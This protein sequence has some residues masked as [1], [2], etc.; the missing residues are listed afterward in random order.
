MNNS[1][2]IDHY[3]ELINNVSDQTQ[4]ELISKNKQF[5]KLIINPSLKIQKFAIEQGIPLKEISNPS[6]E[7]IQIAIKNSSRYG[8]DYNYVAKNVTLQFCVAINEY[9][10]IGY[11]AEN[12]VLDN[13]VIDWA[14]EEL[15][16][17]MP[18][19]D[20]LRV[21]RKIQL[22][23]KQRIRLIELSN[24][25]IFGKYDMV[26]NFKE[27]TKIEID[28]LI[29][30]DWKNSVYIIKN[31]IQKQNDIDYTINQLQQNS[32]FLNECKDNDKNS[33]DSFINMFLSL[34]DNDL[35]SDFLYQMTYIVKSPSLNRKIRKHYNYNDVASALLKKINE[36]NI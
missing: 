27:L 19:E 13:K 24:D 21:F 12:F 26:Y 7:I 18:G 34:L 10:N 3:S 23:S 11:M 31:G 2:K 35:P 17:K 20:V 15:V 32:D 30:L 36:N 33:N 5:F 29:K 16:N 22:D 1:Y 4:K 14:I 28:L 8:F 6:E 9:V 25:F